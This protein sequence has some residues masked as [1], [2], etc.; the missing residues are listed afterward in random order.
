MLMKN[1]ESPLI[2]KNSEKKLILCQKSGV[3]R[4][5]GQTKSITVYES[6]LTK[7]SKKVLLESFLKFNFS[8]LLIIK[9]YNDFLYKLIE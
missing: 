1:F 3:V 6:S 8:N 4:H 5:G 9:N 2:K 7:A